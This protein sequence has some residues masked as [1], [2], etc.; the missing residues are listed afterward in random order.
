MPLAQKFVSLNYNSLPSFFPSLLSLY[1]S[2]FPSSLP[3]L[4]ILK[5]THSDRPSQN[6]KSLKKL[7]R[8]PPEP[9][10]HNQFNVNERPVL[11]KD[12]EL[13][14]LLK[15]GLIRLPVRGLCIAWLVIYWEACFM[16]G[17][18]LISLGMKISPIT[19]HAKFLQ[20]NHSR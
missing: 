6:R 19:I 13:L 7:L 9:K 8:K 18:S 12:R 17:K 16:S 11:N 5:L 15:S 3:P 14:K 10:N 2:C 4:N 1:V 20:V